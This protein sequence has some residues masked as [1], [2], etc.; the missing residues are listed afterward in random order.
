MKRKCCDLSQQNGH[1]AHEGVFSRFGER[2]FFEER[3]AWL[4]FFQNLSMADKAFEVETP[5][6]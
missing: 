6:I 3:D 1:G 2:I 4:T 5:P